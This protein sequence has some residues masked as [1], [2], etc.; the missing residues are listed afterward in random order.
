LNRRVATVIIDV[1]RVCGWLYVIPM[2]LF[3]LFFGVPLMVRGVWW[4][5]RWP[6]AT[7]AAIYLA[8]MPAPA[9]VYLGRDPHFRVVVAASIDWALLGV[10][11]VADHFFLGE[12]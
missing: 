12:P 10:W 9:P 8:E 2:V 3:L 5:F 6:A 7:F 4:V 1:A 11:T